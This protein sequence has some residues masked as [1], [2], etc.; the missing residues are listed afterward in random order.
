MSSIDAR[1]SRDISLRDLNP[2]TFYALGV[3]LPVIAIIFVG[4]GRTP[5]E[6][7]LQMLAWVLLVGLAELLPV[8]RGEA[9]T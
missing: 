4:V 1:P 6:F 3:V 7:E 9:S 5:E 2:A 8:P